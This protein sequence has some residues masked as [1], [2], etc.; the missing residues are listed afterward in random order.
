MSALQRNV[1]S[2]SWCHQEQ[3]SNILL[4]YM[5]CVGDGSPEVAETCL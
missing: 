2:K 1:V 3:H 5:D 4:T